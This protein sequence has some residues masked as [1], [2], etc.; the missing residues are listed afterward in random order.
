MIVIIIIIMHILIETCVYIASCKI[1]RNHTMAIIIPY[2]NNDVMAVRE[3][4]TS[5]VRN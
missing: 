2:D 4:H 1:L 5:A 3:W